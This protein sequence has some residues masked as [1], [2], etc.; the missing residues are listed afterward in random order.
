MRRLICAFVARK[1]QS[2]GF[3]RHIQYD[4]E[5]KASKPPPSYV[6]VPMLTRAFDL[7]DVKCVCRQRHAYQITCFNQLGLT[8]VFCFCFESFRFWQSYSIR[9]S[10][11]LW[12]LVSFLREILYGSLRCFVMTKIVFFVFVFSTYIFTQ[13]KH[14]FLY[15]LFQK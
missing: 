4:V 8:F 10:L 5:A 7:A 13:I 1:R 15:S 11:N 6:P 12:T 2:Q 14:V 9:H 3:S